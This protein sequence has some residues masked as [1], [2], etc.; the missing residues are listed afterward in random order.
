MAFL[1][2]MLAAEDW[3]AVWLGALLLAAAAAGALGPLA[4]H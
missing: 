3:W 2:D 4:K 1:R